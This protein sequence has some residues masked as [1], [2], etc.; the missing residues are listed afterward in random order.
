MKAAVM[1]AF[2]TPLELEDIDISKPGPREVLLRT[3]ASGVCHSDL[4]VLEAGLPVPPPPGLGPQ[5]AGGVEAGGGLVPPAP[6]GGHV[7][8]GPSPFCGG[9]ER[10][11]SALPNKFGRAAPV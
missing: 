9:G 6:P 5:P 11:L 4:H 1:R 2:K 3:A 8:G 7:I 10:S